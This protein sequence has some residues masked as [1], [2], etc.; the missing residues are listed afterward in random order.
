LFFVESWIYSS[1]LGIVQQY[2]AWFP[3]GADGGKLNSLYASK[4]ELYE[5]ARRQVGTGVS[6]E[7]DHSHQTKSQLDIIGVRAGHLPSN[8]P[9]SV[10]LSSGN[11]VSKSSSDTSISNEDLLRATNN[12]EDFYK[13]Y[14]DVTNRAISAY[15]K[16][17]R[18]KSALKLHGSLAALDL[19][20]FNIS[21]YD[22]IADSPVHAGIENDIVAPSLPIV[23]SPFIMHRIHG[24]D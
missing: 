7:C 2:D 15:T 6:F 20:I 3:V 16:A 14:I 9:F 22:P 10:K 1:S 4:G 21:E 5:T 18:R 17:G 23:P 24:P 11:A 19:Y 8:P 12:R 13:L